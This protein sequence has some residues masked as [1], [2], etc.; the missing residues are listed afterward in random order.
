MGFD[1]FLVSTYQRIDWIK[2]KF[3][4]KQVIYMGDGIF[5][6]R[7]MKEVGYGI[8]TF[9]SDPK[10][11]KFANFI[12]KRKEAERA[13]AEAAIHIKQKIFKKLIYEF[14]RQFNSDSKKNLKSH[15]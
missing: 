12:T 10:T 9:D 7:V 14:K 11:K 2:K 13:V 3:N 5:D 6:Y 8:S 15:F 1:L 4:H